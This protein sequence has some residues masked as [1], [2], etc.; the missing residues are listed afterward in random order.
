[1]SRLEELRSSKAIIANPKSTAPPP[2]PPFAPGFGECRRHK[3][4]PKALPARA[5][6]LPSQGLK[7][8]Q[9]SNAPGVAPRTVFRYLNQD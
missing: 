9:I 2:P 1:M 3:G 4:I 7:A 6:K 8:Q 5:I